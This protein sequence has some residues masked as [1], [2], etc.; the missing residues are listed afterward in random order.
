[1]RLALIPIIGEVAAQIAV[2]EKMVNVAVAAGRIG[3]ARGAG[4]SFVTDNVVKMV[5][6]CDI[7]MICGPERGIVVAIFLIQRSGAGGRAVRGYGPYEVIG[8]HPIF[9][10]RENDIIRAVGRS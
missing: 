2:G 3:P 9:A 1:M 4:R 8:T 7:G 5:C 6:A 10:V